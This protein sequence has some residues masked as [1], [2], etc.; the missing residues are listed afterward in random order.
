MSIIL[1]KLVYYLNYQRNQ[2][3]NDNFFVHSQ[4]IKKNKKN[5]AFQKE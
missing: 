2:N 5:V 4:I 1:E 3:Q